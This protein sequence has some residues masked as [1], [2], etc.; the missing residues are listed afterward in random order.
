M[1]RRQS[2]PCKFG[3]SCNVPRCAFRHPEKEFFT[4]SIH[5]SP[6]QKTLANQNLEDLEIIGAFAEFAHMC[7]MNSLAGEIEF[8]NLC[9]DAPY[10][11]QC[12]PDLGFF[13]TWDDAYDTLLRATFITP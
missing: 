3:E 4:N 6:K 2:K 9:P 10:V 12:H 13:K 11:I 5:E 7:E 8:I 1:P